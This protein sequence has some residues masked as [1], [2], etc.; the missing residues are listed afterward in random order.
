[1]LENTFSGSIPSKIGGMT[2]LRVLAADFNSLTGT[3]PTEIGLCTL[4]QELGLSSNDIVSTIPTEIGLLFNLSTCSSIAVE[5]LPWRS[6]FFCEDILTR[7]TYTGA[8][9]LGDKLEGT[10]PSEIGRCLNMTQ[11]VLHTNL[12]LTGTVPSELGSMTAL[13]KLQLHSTMLSGSM[14]DTV[15]SLRALSLKVLDS[16]CINGFRVQCAQPECCTECF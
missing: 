1:M 13:E 9:S 15:C 11:L 14:P 12:R 10:I 8:L 16:D 5:N 3:L 4:L 2:N 7:M 6:I